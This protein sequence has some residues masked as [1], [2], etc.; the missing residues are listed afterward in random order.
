MSHS[1]PQTFLRELD[2]KLWTAA[3]KLR[4]NLDAAVYKHA[5]LGLIFLKYV[6][7]SFAQRQAEIEA[8][9]KDPENDFFVDPASYDKPAQYDEAIHRELEE[10]DYYIEKNVFWVP[11]LARWKT[12]QDSAK[13]PAGTEIKESGRLAHPYKITSTGKL[14][15]DALEAVEKENPKLKN[16]LNKDYVRL[17]IPQENLAGLIDLIATI[18]FQ[19]ADLHAKDIL[20]HV[21]EYFLGQFALA[22]GKKGGQY[23]TPKSIVS[24]IVEMIEPYQGRV[25]DPAMGSGGFFVQS[26]RFI[27]EH[28]GKLGNLSVYGQESNPTTWRLAAMNMAIRGIDFNFGKEP[29]NSFTNGQHPDLRADFVMANPPFNIKEWWDGKLEGDA[30][31]KYGTPP[32]GNANFAWVQHMLHHLAPN[33]SMAL[34]LSNGSMSSN[35]GGEGDIRRALI[36]ADLVECMVALPGQLFTNT[37]IPACIWF[38]TKNKAKRTCPG[39]E[40]LRDR[41]GETLFIDARK[42]GFMKDRVLRDFTEEDVGKIAGTFH[43]WRKELPSPHGRRTGDEANPRYADVAGFRKSATLQEIATHGHVLTPG[44]Y[45]GAEDVED[46]GEA[47]EDKMTR[48]TADLALQFT[49]SAKLESA[50]KANLKGLGYAL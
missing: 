41:R 4:S 28:G 35:S 49:E 9:L 5:V 39:A 50:I 19:H 21:Y 18:P 38:L 2:K 32:Q 23:F 43:E 48:L 1:S 3:D 11:A 13:L 42:L 22:E 29:A 17:Q 26:E 25:Y 16:V 37:Q 44:R 46:D 36:E 10:R 40:P 6:S 8:M 33:G 31:W 14:I 12:L 27:E 34:L 45:V 24:L 7:D 30:R 15:D 47:F 20:G